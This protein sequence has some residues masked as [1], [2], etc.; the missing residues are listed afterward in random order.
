MLDSATSRLPRPWRA[1]ADLLLVVV[2]AFGIVLVLEAEVAKPLSIP[3]SS[4]EPTLHCARPV[5]GCE[6]RFSDRVIVCE[7][8]YRVS[9]P[10][11]GQ[12]VAFRAPAAAVHVCGE[13]GVYVKRLIGF[14]GESV[15]EDLRGRIWVDGHRLNQPYISAAD[16]LSD[17]GHRGQTWHVRAGSYFVLGDNRGASCDSRLW[18]GVPRS[19]LIGPVVLTYWPPTRIVFDG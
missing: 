9:G 17:S 15:R 13:G 8:C 2:V 7:I 5:E 4:M 3:T 14:P 19:S 16:R 10:E 1:V 18:G 6:A 11:R 12:I